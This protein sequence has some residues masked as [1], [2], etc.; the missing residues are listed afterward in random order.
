MKTLKYLLFCLFVIPAL[1]ACDKPGDSPLV[2]PD[3]KTKTEY[4]VLFVGNSFTYYNGGVDFHLQKMLN[5]DGSPDS[6]KYVIQEIASGSYTLQ[7]HYED[8][9]TLDKIRNNNWNIVVLQEQSTRPVNNPDL[10]SEYASYLDFEIKKVNAK[11]VLYMT[12]ATKYQPGDID[13]IS[14][15]YNSVGLDLNAL[16][17]PVGQVW[18]YALV[19]SPGI[20]LYIEDFKHPTLSGTYLTACVFFY[21]LFDRNPVD[22]KYVP[23]GMST[24]NVLLIRSIVYDYMQTTK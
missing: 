4:K 24:E 21:S 22:N 7:A 20:E 23:S 13:A 6:V 16:V 19:N 12:W 18:E 11:T 8:Q 2:I 9:N 3:V 1:W 14:A 15:S 5:A 17:V 10:F